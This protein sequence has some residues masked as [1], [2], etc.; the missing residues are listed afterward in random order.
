MNARKLVRFFLIS[1]LFSIP[2][3]LTLPCAEAWQAV[4]A[5]GLHTCGMKDNGTVACW[6]SNAWKQIESPSGTFID[7]AGELQPAPSPRFSGTPAPTP[8]PKSP[9]CS[10]TEAVLLAA[11]LSAGDYAALKANG[12]VA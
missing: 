5:G 4:T 8:R 10:D 7:V 1:V 9:D 3:S 11:G 12:V 2:L 6:G